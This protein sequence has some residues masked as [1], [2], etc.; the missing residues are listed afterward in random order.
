[1]HVVVVRLRRPYT[2]S[3]SSCVRRSMQTL[4]MRLYIVYEYYMYTLTYFD[5]YYIL[6]TCKHRIEIQ[7]CLILHHSIIFSCHSCTYYLCVRTYIR[8]YSVSCLS[9]FLLPAIREG[10]GGLLYYTSSCPHPTNY[11]IM[12]AG[13]QYMASHARLLA[14]L[15]HLCLNI[16]L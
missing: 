9:I 5:L 11:L 14:L 3:S 7:R 2:L 16:Y 6:A 1:M 10:R 8:V 15:A 13:I 4:C 12:H